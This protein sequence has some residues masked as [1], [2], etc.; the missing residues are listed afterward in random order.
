MD[1][2]VD[3]LIEVFTWVGLGGF[4]ALAVVAVGLWAADGSWLPADAVIDRDGDGPVARWIDDDGDVNSAPL[5]D[6]DAQ[7][8]GEAERATVWY[9]HGWRDRMRLVRRP[10]S[11]RTVIISA[12][13]MLAL[14]ILCLVA[15]WVLYFARG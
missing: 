13:G 6:A 3:I 14:G 5:T 4:V 2:T 7:S 8:L 9:R 11:L 10:T 1:Q 12:G 15:G